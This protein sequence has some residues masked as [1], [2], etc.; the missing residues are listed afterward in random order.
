M[1]DS[2]RQAV[3]RSLQEIARA[4]NGDPKT[5]EV[6]PLFLVNVCLHQQRVEFRP[7]LNQYA[8]IY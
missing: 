8:M 3:K 5:G 1:E 7:S 4:I 2:L 6:Y